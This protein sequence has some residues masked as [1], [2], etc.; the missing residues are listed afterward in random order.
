MLTEG[1]GHLG[2]GPWG[3]AGM[4]RTE[5]GAGVG[6]VGLEQALKLPSQVSL[7]NTSGFTFP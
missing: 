3:L 2:L 4:G 7:S 5:A 6:R 1:V